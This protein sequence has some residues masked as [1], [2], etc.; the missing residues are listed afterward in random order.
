MWKDR[1]YP[2]PLLGLLSLTLIFLLF[3]ELSVKPTVTYRTSISTSCA[4]YHGLLWCEIYHYPPHSLASPSGAL[5]RAINSN[6]DA[7]PLKE[8]VFS[9][10]TWQKG[11]CFLQ[12]P[13]EA[14]GATGPIA[15]FVLLCQ[16][17]DA[18]T[19]TQRKQGTKKTTRRWWH[20]AAMKCKSDRVEF[21]RHGQ[22]SGF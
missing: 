20:W 22:G 15:K 1:M 14:L 2:C 18:L 21:H 5:N 16:G 17:H 7:L 19:N 11:H 12:I 4:C 13:W 10:Y 3:T 6:T 9:K 8:R